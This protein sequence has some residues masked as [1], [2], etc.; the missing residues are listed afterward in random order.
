V[1]APEQRGL[2]QNPS[3]QDVRCAQIAAIPETARRTG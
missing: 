1:L 2:Q 3:I